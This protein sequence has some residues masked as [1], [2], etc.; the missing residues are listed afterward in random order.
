[1]TLQDIVNQTQYAARKATLGIVLGFSLASAPGLV[2]AGAESLTTGINIATATNGAATSVK[3]MDPTGVVKPLP[4]PPPPL[5]PFDVPKIDPLPI[6]PSED[7]NGVQSRIVVKQ[8]EQ[9]SIKREINEEYNQRIAEITSRSPTNY[10]DIDGNTSPPLNI[11]KNYTSFQIINGSVHYKAEK[12]PGYYVHYPHAQ[13]IYYV[14]RKDK[15]TG[16]GRTTVARFITDENGQLLYRANEQGEMVRVQS[17]VEIRIKPKDEKQSTS[18]QP[19]KSH[20]DYFVNLF[21]CLARNELRP[22]AE[23]GSLAVLGS[24]G[25][26]LY[27]RHRR[28]RSRLK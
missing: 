28:R 10:E 7:N 15:T 19:E 20:E 9:S 26:T 22:A 1:M 4:P 18:V 24:I 23:V 21:G 14:E 11:L 27:I 25:A 12:I 2:Y 17:G 3:L 16:E 5:L 13:R 8:R 6:G